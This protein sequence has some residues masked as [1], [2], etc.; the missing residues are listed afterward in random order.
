[1]KLRTIALGLALI[2]GA[3]GCSH[4]E[5]LWDISAS[6][7]YQEAVDAAAAAEQVAADLLAKGKEA[8]EN[9][10]EAWD[11]VEQLTERVRSGELDSEALAEATQAL[12]V[13]MAAYDQGQAAIEEI[14]AQADEARGAAET[15]WNRA[16]DLADSSGIPTWLAALLAV[17]GMGV[18]T[19]GPF[20]PVLGAVGPLLER[21]GLRN[22]ERRMEYHATREAEERARANAKANAGA[23]L[24]LPPSDGDGGGSA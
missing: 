24:G 10:A 18:P 11:Q 19:S 16:E 12:A 17:L 5:R 6:P 14:K 2:V 1:M 7:E 13:A 4:L 21:T 8:A 9:A 20:A 23:L 22:R 3:T 15:A